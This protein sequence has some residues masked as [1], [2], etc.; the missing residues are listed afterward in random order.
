[1]ADKSVDLGASNLFSLG[2]NFKAQ[3]S[4]SPHERTPATV[5]DADGDVACESM[6]DNMTT[7]SNS[8]GYCNDTPD[9]KT[10]LGANL[11]AFGTVADSKMLDEIVIN[12]ERGA[13]ATVDVTGHNH[14]NN[15]HASTDAGVS[16]VSAAVPAS[17]GFGVP[18][19]GVTVGSDA[20]P[21][22]A[23]LTINWR[24]HVDENDADGEHWSGKNTGPQ[25]TLSLEF[26]GLPT[27]QTVAA[28]ESDMTGWTIDTNGPAD[29]NSQLDR[30]LLTAHQ[31]FSIT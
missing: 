13:Q 27:S 26:L 7:Y 22:S 18:A 9:I 11:T 12:F 30:F 25:A 21:I 17:A 23:T 20:T 16:D 10:D 15:A 19:F 5:I 4:S 29:D 28:L 3:N 8:F 24:N 31:N 2:A 1:M 14:D 6:I